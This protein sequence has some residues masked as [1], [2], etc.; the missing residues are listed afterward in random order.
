[1][2]KTCK[3]LD[4]TIVPELKLEQ[5]VTA[6]RIGITHA[7]GPIAFAATLCKMLSSFV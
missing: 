1:V 2:Y 3:N 7:I 6:I 4:A 5:D